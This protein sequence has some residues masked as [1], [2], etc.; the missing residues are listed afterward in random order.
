MSPR[1]REGG[2]GRVCHRQ[3]PYR[4]TVHDGRTEGAQRTFQGVKQRRAERCSQTMPARP[5]CPQRK[6]NVRTRQSHL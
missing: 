1:D 3:T 4:Y 2:A 5:P 6:V